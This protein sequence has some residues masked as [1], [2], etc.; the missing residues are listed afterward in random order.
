MAGRL[1]QVGPYVL[2]RYLGEGA[3]GRVVYGHHKDTRQHVAV[4]IISK[5]Q[6]VK[7]Q[8]LRGMVQREVAAD[9]NPV[10]R[11]RLIMSYVQGRWARFV[12]SG[13]EEKPTEDWAQAQVILFSDLVSA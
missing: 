6:F 2:D 3:T 8:A 12:A 4:K 7:H 11:A 9:I 5:D 10:V 1:E 13:F